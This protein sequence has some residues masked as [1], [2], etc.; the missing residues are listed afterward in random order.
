MTLLERSDPEHW[1][2]RD[3]DKGVQVNIGVAIG[4]QASEDARRAIVPQVVIREIASNNA[5]VPALDT[6]LSPVREIAPDFR[7]A[8]TEA[9]QEGEGHAK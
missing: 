9:N 8:V 3:P 4:V 1:G 2:R 6:P 5:I 7:L